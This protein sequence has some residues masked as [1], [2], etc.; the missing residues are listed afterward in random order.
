MQSATL[1]ISYTNLS[2]SL[3]T[4]QICGLNYF[5]E[6][7]LSPPKYSKEYCILKISIVLINIS[8]N[9]EAYILS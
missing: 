8:Y 4:S 9:L 7:H 1:N 6:K 2:Q 5:K 3:N